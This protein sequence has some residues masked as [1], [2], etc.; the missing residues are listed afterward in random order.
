MS[1]AACVRKTRTFWPADDGL[2]PLAR[3]PLKA[4]L[5]AEIAGAVDEE[6]VK[7]IRAAFLQREKTIEHEIDYKPLEVNIA[8]GM[9]YNF[10]RHVHARTAPRPAARLLC[11]FAWQQVKLLRAVGDEA[12]F[13]EKCRTPTK[14]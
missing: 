6:E 13:C 4:Q 8:L 2:A 7:T 9:S 1:A 5:E 11:S 14:M 12:E 3:R 10:L